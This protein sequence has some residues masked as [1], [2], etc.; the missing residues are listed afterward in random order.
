MDGELCVM[1]PGIS[2]MQQWFVISWAMSMHCLLHV[3]LPLE[4]AVD[5]Y[6]WIM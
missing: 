5:Q 4:Q 2:L 6:G 1:T 3:V